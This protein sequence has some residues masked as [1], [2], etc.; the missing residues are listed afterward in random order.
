MN[1]LNLHSYKS[2]NTFFFF[3][4]LTQFDFI[5]KF[6]FPALPASYAAVVF[7][8]NSYLVE[9]QFYVLVNRKT[10]YWVFSRKANSRGRLVILRV[11]LVY[12]WPETHFLSAYATPTNNHTGCSKVENTI[13]K[14]F[15]TCSSYAQPAHNGL[16]GAFLFP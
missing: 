9:T 14:S 10:F 3:F 4:V 15:P 5:P 2:F 7:L 12:R 8:K 16:K 13:Y 1:Q 11:S 6:Q